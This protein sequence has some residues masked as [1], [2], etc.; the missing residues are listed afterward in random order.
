MSISPR[1]SPN[2]QR[3]FPPSAGPTVPQRKQ[4]TAPR[5]GVKTALETGRAELEKPLQKRTVEQYKSM[6]KQ[7]Q[8]RAAR[9]AG[10]AQ[11]AF[12]GAILASAGCGSGVDRVDHATVP[13]AVTAGTTYYVSPSGND[14]N[15]GKSTARAFRTIAKVNALALQP[16][17]TVAFEGGESFTGPLTISRSGTSR[18]PIRITSF[19]SATGLDRAEILAGNGDGMVIR[20]AEYVWVSKVKVVGSGTASN[21]GH[22]IMLDRTIAGTSRLRCIYLDQVEVSGFYVTGVAFYAI[23]TSPVGY[24]DIRLTNA[25]IHDNGYAGV[26]M[27]G[28]G[29]G[30]P[31]VY[32][33]N[34]V[35]VTHS[36]IHDN[37]GLDIPEQTGNGIFLKDVNGG[38]IEHCLAYNNGSLNRNTGGGPVGIW[39][40]FS[41]NVTIQ[42]NESYNN[43]TKANDGG[44]FDLDGGVTNSVMQ[45]NYSHGNDGAGF[46]IWDFHDAMHNQNNIVRYNISQNDG[47]SPKRYGGIHVGSQDAGQISSLEIYGNTVYN[48]NGSNPIKFDGALQ[49][50]RIRNNILMT[51]PGT[52]VVRAV[53]GQAGVLMQG[54]ICR[55]SW[56]TPRTL[57]VEKHSWRQWPT[58]RRSSGSTSTVYIY[59]VIS[60]FRAAAQR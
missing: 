19:T 29:G 15:D 39:A 11:L 51:I 36:R 8:A 7:R 46:L 35:R 25:D 24:D 18:Q 57:P 32:C 16:G 50:V 59:R 12:F 41:N 9:M 3:T 20:D 31:G 49:N 21:R 23:N 10:L 22:G 52:S 45:Y 48:S 34:N 17:D 5:E 28:C 37:L 38:T 58:A 6:A 47:A 30:G 4:V 60:R 13:S 54:N 33:F 56:K 2:A 42:F 55:R 1:S 26:W 53:R 40:I 27:G 14:A 44:G 43:H